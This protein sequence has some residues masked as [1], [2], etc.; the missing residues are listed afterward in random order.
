MTDNKRMNFNSYEEVE[1]FL[2]SMPRFQDVGA[3]AA[4]FGLDQIE[5]FSKAIGN[6]HSE[7][8]SI[9]VAGTN[10]KGTVC[11]MLASIFLEAGYK[12]GLYTSPHLSDVRE[13]FVINGVTISKDEL[14]EFFQMHCEAILH[15][16]ITFFELTT[17]IAFWWFA[18]QRVDIAIIETGLGGRLDATNLILPEVSVITSIGLDH[19]EQLGDTLE[20]VALEKAGIIKTGV[21]HVIGRVDEHVLKVIGSQAL[22]MNSDRIQTVDTV[23]R[24]STDTLQI[25]FGDEISTLTS[26]VFSPELEQ[27]VEICLSVVRAV[28]QNFFVSN[29][30]LVRGL[31]NIRSNSGLKGRFEKLHPGLNWYFDGAHNAQALRTVLSQIN[32]M[33]DA[34][35]EPVIVLTMMRDKFNAPVIQILSEYNRIF[36]YELNV[37]RSL[38]FTEFNQK[39]PQAISLCDRQNEIKTLLNNLKSNLVLFTG[40]FYFYSNV[41]EWMESLTFDSICADKT[42]S[43]TTIDKVEI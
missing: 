16:Q 4:Y 29:L 12:T 33:N 41:T 43:T 35:A 11:S 39:L 10:G 19:T 30:H 42:P 9:H 31:S 1:S 6:P 37:P 28:S 14:T 24:I 36:F 23:T 25:V 17:A 8:K 26:D 15:H 7:F 32:R 40:S 5:V 34:S 21:P 13:R 20:S 22:R 18:K 27:N 38:N 3:R 2:L